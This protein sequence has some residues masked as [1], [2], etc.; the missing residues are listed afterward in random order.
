VADRFAARAGSESGVG[1]V[2]TLSGVLAF[3]GFLLVATQVLV[4]LYAT[5]VATAASFDAARVLA[6]DADESAAVARA[7]ALLGSYADDA[8]VDADAGEEQVRVQ[9]RVASP[10]LIPRLFGVFDLG[11]IDRTAVLRR[12]ELRP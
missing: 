11:A 10:A 3:L 4:H 5:S 12:E 2:G 7:R 6:V 8:T 9:V 1:A